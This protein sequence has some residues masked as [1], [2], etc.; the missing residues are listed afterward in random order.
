MNKK[1]KLSDDG[2]N[3]WGKIGGGKQLPPQIDFS[4]KYLY[5][6]ILNTT[7]SH[8]RWA[9]GTS[10]FGSV[11]FDNSLSAQPHDHMRV[12]REI[13]IVKNSLNTEI[14]EKN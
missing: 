7:H 2:I 10:E 9:E 14:E 3:S 12:S 8:R 11:P 6:Y 5:D 1:K 13:L 4:D